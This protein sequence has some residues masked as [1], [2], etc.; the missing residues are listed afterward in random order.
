[1]T[2]VLVGLLAAVAV[3]PGA[4]LQ[5][6][7]IAADSARGAQ[8]F[9][10]LSCVQ[11]HSVNGKGGVIG[12]DLGRRIDRNFTPSGLAAT[13]WNHAPTMW[14]LMRANK[15]EPGALTEQSAA[16]LFAYFYSNRF[17]E[18]TGDAGRGKRLFA[19]KHCAD[20]HGLKEAKIPEAQPVAQWEST[21]R[22]IVLVNAM[23]NHAA[24]MRQEFAKRKFTWPALTAQDLADMLVYLR[25][26]PGVPRTMERVEISAGTNGQSLF[27][28][29]GCSGCH[30]DK[31]SIV[32][33]IK[34]ET[35]TGIAVAMWNHEPKMAPEP[36]RLE[37]DEM[38]EIASYLWAEQFF[39]DE[40]SA[41]Q[42]GRVFTA[43]HC[44]TCHN[45]A[46]SGAPKLIGAGRSF[47]AATMVSAL[48]YHGPQMLN[49]MKTRNIAWPR[50]DGRDMA[51]LIAY[52]N[53]QNGRK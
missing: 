21:G 10:T 37:V 17:F 7:T 33:Q 51:N 9:E 45:D 36:A 12:P 35:L 22:P 31:A 2:R 5:G 24:T 20:C 26:L 8:L 49:L 34:G 47:T 43:K 53:V 32:R 42:G 38:R 3:L 6:A 18:Q 44:A 19:A 23:W 11:C 1:M 30:K 28:S 15:I 29:K 25:N 48:W 46:S 16:D 39:A 41:A 13:M 50:L 52:L 4:A 40:G 27:D 14:S